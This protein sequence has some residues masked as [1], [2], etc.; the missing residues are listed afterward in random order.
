MFQQF[1]LQVENQFDNNIKYVQSDNGGEFK[2]FI[3][4][5]QHAGIVHRFSCPYNSTQNGRVERKHRHVVETGLA[6][7]AHAS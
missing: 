4:F 2:S 6:L 7:L 1:K 3:I 5:L